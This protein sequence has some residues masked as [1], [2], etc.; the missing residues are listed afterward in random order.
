VNFSLR[1]ACAV[2]LPLVVACSTSER[3][4]W[5]DQARL[6]QADQEPGQWMA[7]GRTWHGQRF[8]PL[9]RISTDNVSRLGF[10]WEYTARSRRGRV[11]HGQEATPIMVDGVI[12]ASGPW[13]SVMAVDA[14]TG[15]ER[16]RYDPEVDGSYNRR[17]CCDVVNRG[18]AVWK[19]RV[20]VATL[21]GFLVALD[22]A[23]AKQIWRA[24]TFT[25]RDSRFYTITGPPQVAGNVVV[26]GNSGAE[27]GVRGYVTAYDLDTGTQKWR[28][29]TVP[30]DPAKGAP[31]NPAMEVAAK[32]WGAKTD[33]E[34]GLGG[35]VWGEMSYDPELGLLVRD[36]E[37]LADYDVR[38][39][40]LC[41]GGHR[42]QDLQTQLSVDV[43]PPDSRTYLLNDLA[44]T[45][46]TRR[47]M[48]RCFGASVQT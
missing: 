31:E 5:V 21:D 28:F 7:L 14:R 17:A 27:Y 46:F 3:A 41:V 23:N 42:S 44:G 48:S 32:T 34:S 45:Y 24:D 40:L 2:A 26:I 20:Y 30:G 37:C 22:A 16:W 29:Y 11:E 35:T 39:P 1:H 6:G 10:A 19:G 18:L 36:L 38:G 4:G 43:V 13:G 15:Q 47:R 12:Y 9:T 8:S 33:W 25:D